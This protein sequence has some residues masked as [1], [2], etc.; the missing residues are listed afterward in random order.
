[1]T[2]ADIEAATDNVD[3]DWGF[4]DC[5]PRR[6][7]QTLWRRIRLWVS[8]VGRDWHAGR[9]GPFTAARVCS[10]IHPWREPVKAWGIVNDRRESR[11]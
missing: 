1:M 10:C 7:S 11:G 2:P 3:V 9:I 6:P 5:G 4:V 8:I